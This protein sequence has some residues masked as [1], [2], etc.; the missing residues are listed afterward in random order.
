MVSALRANGVPFR[1]SFLFLPYAQHSQLS[2]LFILA[3]YERHTRQIREDKI[4]SIN[5]MPT[6]RKSMF[7]ILYLI[8]E[9]EFI[10]YKIYS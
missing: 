8:I 3:T 2:I 9:V 6:S 10:L 1:H 4:L 7:C 5:A